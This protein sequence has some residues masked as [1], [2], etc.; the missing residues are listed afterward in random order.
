MKRSVLTVLGLVLGMVLLFSSAGFCDDPA[1]YVLGFTLEV[2]GRRADLGIA[3]QRGAELALE[4]VNAAGGVNGRKLKAIF[5]D[6][7]SQPVANVKNTKKIIDSDKAIACMGY[8]SVG[9]TLAS[10][11][12]ATDGET[13]LFSASPALV[14]GGKTK[15]WLFTVVPDQKIA[16]IPILVQNLLN[17][18]SKKIAYVYVD[19]AYGKLGSAAFK[20]VCEKLNIT[21]AIMEEYSPQ[22]VDLSPQISHIKASG[23]DGLLITGNLADT[24]KVIKTA[25]DLGFDS[26]IVCDYAIVGPEFIQLGGDLVEGIV[27]TSLKALVAHELPDSDPQKKIAVKLYDEYTKKYKTFSL[28]PGHTWDQVE[29]L[30]DALKN[31]DPKL[32]PTKDQDLVIIRAQVRDSLEKVHGVVGQNGIFNYSPTDHIGLAEGCYIP[33]VVKDGKWHLYKD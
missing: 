25:R 4:E 19:T 14:T 10:V 32:D 5:Y 7:E 26:P 22:A 30:V 20:G 24:V 31:V 27:S 17:R 23:A 18:G 11:Q 1:P 3:E 16:S 29:L 21:P 28:Y 12:T 8:T 13:L 6:G 15:K 2:T 33:V 9:G